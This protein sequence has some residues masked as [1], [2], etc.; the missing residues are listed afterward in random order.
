MSSSEI[1]AKFLSSI[2][3]MGVPQDNT[4]EQVR[5]LQ[6]NSQELDRRQAKFVPGASAGDYLFTDQK[7]P[8][9]NGEK[10]FRAQIIAMR[11]AWVEK[12]PGNAGTVAE[13]PRRP[14]DAVWTID[15][16]TGRNVLRRLNGNNVEET[17]FLTLALAGEEGR[18]DHDSLYNMRVRSTGLGTLKTQLIK[19]LN[20]KSMWIEA[21]EV[22]QPS[23]IFGVIVRVASVGMSNANGAWYMP[24]FEILG[25]LGQA[26][27]PTVTDFLAALDMHKAIAAQTL[28]PAPPPAL[29]PR[30]TIEITSGR[31][32]SAPPPSNDDVPAGMRLFAPIDDD[33]PF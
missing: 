24:S 32:P 2:A 12:L 7:P 14:P 4:L 26:A 20:K 33:I 15:S 29:P 28:P 8:V 3:G 18:V 11:P 22:S 1:N 30:G 13:H 17:V 23:P 31:L 9:V 27:G 6:S 10:G 25:K 5:L 16:E 21:D 19:P